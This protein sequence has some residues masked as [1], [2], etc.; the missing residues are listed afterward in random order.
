MKHA[1]IIDD[2]DDIREV[3]QLS[4]EVSGRYRVTAAP[5]GPRGIEAATAD[6]PDVI[7]L[8]YMMPE[9][10]GPAT[11][12]ALRERPETRTLPVLILTARTAESLHDEVRSL[13]AQGLLEKPFDPLALA[14][15]IDQHMGWT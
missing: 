6:P 2:D 5:D 11:L 8:D 9:M 12:R 14:D 10:D 1:L 7:L 3:A 4:L 15:L 13:G